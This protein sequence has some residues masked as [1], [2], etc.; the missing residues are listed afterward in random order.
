[1]AISGTDINLIENSLINLF[2]HIP[3]TSSDRSNKRK[4]E[5][6]LKSFQDF[7]SDKQEE[8]IDIFT[9]SVRD[10]IT[11]SDASKIKN[12]LDKAFQN[13]LGVDLWDRLRS[14]E[15]SLTTNERNSVIRSRIDNINSEVRRLRKIIISAKWSRSLEEAEKFVILSQVLDLSDTLT[16]K[17][18]ED[19][20]WSSTNAIKEAN[21]FVYLTL[22]LLLRFIAMVKGKVTMESLT[23]TL[24][25]VQVV[26][27]E[28]EISSFT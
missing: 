22:F 2:N 14:I 26:I 28:Q 11:T 13:E 15:Y 10:F 27:E 23:Y 1:M 24:S 19:I 12:R 20:D 25:L 3:E 8:V 5:R 16:R 9:D 21:L 6:A 4:Y 7:L 18:L 17:A